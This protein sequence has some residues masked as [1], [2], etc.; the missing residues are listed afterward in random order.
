MRSAMRDPR[1]PSSSL[2][3]VDGEQAVV[4]GSVD[5][6]QAVVE[7]SVDGEQA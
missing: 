1:S 5:G 2:G 7:G 6:E 4:E 3:S